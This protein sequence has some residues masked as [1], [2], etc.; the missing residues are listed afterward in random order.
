MP[1]AVACPA[2]KMERTLDELSSKPVA[3]NVRR[4]VR[5]W[6]DRTRRVRLRYAVLLECGD[7]ETASRV[8]SKGGKT[9]SPLTETVLE[10]E[11]GEPTT[12]IAKKLRDVG[13][14]LE[15]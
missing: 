8:L 3:Q 7:P 11:D 4:Q 10:L 13:I 1:F 9:L 2:K 14:F 15:E 5:Y 12:R 6:A